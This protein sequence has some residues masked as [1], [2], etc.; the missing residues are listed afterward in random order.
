MAEDYIWIV[1]E[2]PALEG[3]RDGGVRRNPYDDADSVAIAPRRGVPVQ[4]AKLE[5]GMSDFL[6]VMGRVLGQV[7]QRSQELS[8]ME[9]DEIELSVEINGEG[10]VSLLGSGGKIGGSSGMTLKFKRSPTP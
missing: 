4:A 6:Q 9:L 1:T 5:Q 2:T 8:G 7:R 3:T 10:Q